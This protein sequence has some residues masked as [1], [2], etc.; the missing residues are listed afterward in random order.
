MLFPHATIFS[1][2]KNIYPTLFI[3]NASAKNG[4]KSLIYQ[5]EGDES[6]A[7]LI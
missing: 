5:H 1:R 2:W 7:V 6:S 3:Y 4:L